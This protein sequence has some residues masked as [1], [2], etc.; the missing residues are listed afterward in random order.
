M[1]V[2]PTSFLCI[3]S[4]LIQCRIVEAEVNL[5]EANIQS[6]PALDT[7]ARYHILKIRASSD[8]Y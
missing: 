1:N 4:H 8:L 7:R 3:L 2:V 5:S 6:D